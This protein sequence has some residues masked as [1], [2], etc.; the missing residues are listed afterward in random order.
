MLPAPLSQNRAAATT[1]R[2][3]QIGEAEGALGG[4]EQHLGEQHG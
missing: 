4:T 1:E 3:A 2:P